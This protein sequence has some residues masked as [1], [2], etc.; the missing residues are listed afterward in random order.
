MLAEEFGIPFIETSCKSGYGVE[1]TF[2]ELIR[3][4]RT[5]YSTLPTQT[6]KLPVQ[7][8]QKQKQTQKKKCIV[9]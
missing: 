5:C 7:L 4:G 6:N 1:H 2:K 3:W 9:S 8:K